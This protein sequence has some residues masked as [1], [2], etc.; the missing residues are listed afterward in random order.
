M[1]LFVGG[2]PTENVQQSKYDPV[3]KIPIL[4]NRQIYGC[5]EVENM[6]IRAYLDQR[7]KFLFKNHQFYPKSC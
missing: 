7:T 6:V 1:R 4:T 3:V 5:Y 2:S